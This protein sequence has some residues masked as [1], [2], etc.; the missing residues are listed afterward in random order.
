V[1]VSLAT[2][3][4]CA[5]WRNLLRL[6]GTL[7]DGQVISVSGTLTGLRQS[8][9]IVEINGFETELA[10]A[11]HMMFLSYTDR[12]G[13]VGVVGQILGSRQINIAG[14]QVCRDVQGGEALIALTVDSA[15]PAEAVDEIIAAIGATGARVADLADD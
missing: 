8:P 12:P 3:P 13:I 1:E 6:S 10:P 4:E 11:D 5:D 7:P 9:K 2:T 14:M 15:V